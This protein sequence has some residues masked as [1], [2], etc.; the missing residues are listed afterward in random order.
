[1]IS[2]RPCSRDSFCSVCAV[3]EE[4]TNEEKRRK[5]KEHVHPF[6]PLSVFVQNI[7]FALSLV[8]LIL[9]VLIIHSTHST[10]KCIKRKEYYSNVDLYLFQAVFS[11]SFPMHFVTMAHAPHMSDAA[12]RLIE[13][14]L[15]ANPELAKK[16]AEKNGKERKRLTTPFLLHPFRVCGEGKVARFF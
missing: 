1:M 16:A 6:S 3:R 10:H 2:H 13:E 8:Q 14:A 12:R 5:S 7:N 4:K 15:A 11:L 9:L